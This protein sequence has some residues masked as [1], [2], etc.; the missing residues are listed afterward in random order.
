ML[1]PSGFSFFFLTALWFE[2]RAS[3][4]Q[5]ALY[6]LSHSSSPFCSVILEIIMAS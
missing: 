4:L 3:L 1:A 6:H 5:Q 2:L